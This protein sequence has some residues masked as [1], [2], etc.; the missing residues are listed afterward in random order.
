ML[1]VHGMS[2][3]ACANRVTAALKSISGVKDVEVSLEMKKATIRFESEH[4][5]EGKLKQ[6]VTKEG[7]LV[8]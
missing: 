4:S 7:Y 5:D 2:C 3:Q 8:E 1:K 6:A